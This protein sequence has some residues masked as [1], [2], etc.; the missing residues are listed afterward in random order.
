MARFD[1][2]SL[3]TVALTGI[4][5]LVLILVLS[6]HLL[7][8]PSYP[9]KNLERPDSFEVHITARDS[10]AMRQANT[11][12][13]TALYDI[14]RADRPFL[15][16]RKWTE[17]TLQLP[18]PF[19]VFCR[20]WDV[21]W[22]VHAR[23]NRETLII[24]EDRFPLE[25]LTDRVRA[26]LTRVAGGRTNPEWTN[27]RYIPLQFS[28]AVWLTRAMTR[29][30]FHSHSFFWIDAGLS[31]FF[32]SSD[33][34]FR[35]ARPDA[36]LEPDRFYITL[37]GPPVKFLPEIGS[38]KAYLA[39]GFFGGR[40]MPVARVC[41]A[42]LVFL[43]EEMLEK[44]RIDNEQVAFHHIYQEHLDWFRVQNRKALG[45]GYICM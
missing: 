13:V 27:P 33:M 5:W 14:G 37:D 32:D 11:S 45:C 42:L 4:L 35:L 39:G 17:E 25:N 38:Q 8:T 10:L 29:N 44:D 18:Y 22:I 41:S 9:L 36:D 7:D 31:R 20:P 19:V 12:L 40:A 26:I 3:C 6:G 2:Q 15:L 16:Y 30:P 1:K 28:K 34:S 23:A 21:H 43:Q 24:V